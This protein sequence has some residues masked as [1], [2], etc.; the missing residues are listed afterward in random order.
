MRIAR[1][2]VILGLFLTAIGRTTL[3][4]SGDEPKPSPPVVV[5]VDPVYLFLN[6]PNDLDS[7]W[8]LIGRPDRV[9]LDGNQYRKLLDS[10][11]RPKPLE[12]RSPAVIES[13]LVAGQVIGDWAHLKL[14]LRVT[15]DHDEPEWIG[16]R[17]DGQTL[18]EAREGTIDLPT[19]MVGDRAW[20]VELSKKGNHLVQVG[21]IAPVKS[22]V[23]GK[24]IELMIPAAASTAIDLKLPVI[25]LDGSTGLNEKLAIASTDGDPAG[26]RL[27]ARL[28]PRSRLELNWRERADP[29]VKLPPLLEARGDVA[30]DVEREAILTRSTWGINSIRGTSGQLLLRL[31]GDEEILDILV[32]SR[33]VPWETRRE[34]G[35]S[36]VVIPL[37]EP[38]R[39]GTSRSLVLTTRRPI[40]S[41]GTV[42]AVLEGYS[43]DQA[44]VETGM[45]AVSRSGPLF[46]NPMSSRG[47]RRIDPRTELSESLRRRADTVLG[48][49][50]N[51]PP[52][53]L[54]LR[55][56]PA[57]PRL[58]VEEWTTIQIDPTTAR[59]QTRLDCRTSQGRVFE[60]QVLLPAGLDL[61]S[62]EP[63]D[64]VAS[65]HV[66][67]LNQPGTLGVGVDVPRILS[68]TL[69]PKAREDDSFAIYL[70]GWAAIDPSKSVAVPLFRPVADLSHGGRFAVVTDRNVAVELRPT[71]DAPANFRSDWAQPPTDWV[72]PGRKPGPEQN[73]LWLRTDAS[74]ETIPFQVT[75]RPRT[76]RHETTLTATIDRRGAEIV[77]EI[78]GEV[79]F[80]TLGKLDLSIPREVNDR[81]EVEGGDRT[82]REPLVETE[83]DGSRRYRLRFPRD[84]TDTFRLRIRY[85]LP[86]VKTDP[87]EAGG[88][89][90]L[91]PIR[92]LEGTSTGRKIQIAIEP[93]FEVQPEATG[94]STETGSEL[95]V[96]SENGLPI[97][98]R[99]TLNSEKAGPVALIVRP[100]SRLPL[101]GVM[102][103]RLW[104][105]TSQRPDNELAT[106]AFFWVES[107]ET[108]MVIGLDPGTR[109]VRT[110]VGTSELGAGAVEQVRPDEYRLRFPANTPTGPI[111]VAIDT[112]V[113]ASATRESWPAPRLLGG[114][115]VQQT[116]WEALLIGNRAGVGTPAGWLD[117]NEWFWDGLIWQRRPWKSPL[118]LTNW[119]TAGNSR[120]RPVDSFDPDDRGNRHSYLFS[121][122]G[123]PTS[124]RFVIFSRFTLLLL[125]SGPVLMAGLLVLAFRPPPRLTTAALLILVFALGSVVDLSVVFLVLQSSVL[126]LALFLTAVVI[127]WIIER[128][129]PSRT[130]GDLG[131]IVPITPGSTFD[132]SPAVGSEDSTAI[133]V[134]PMPPS[135]VST[136]DHIVLTRNFG[137]LS[138]VERTPPESDLP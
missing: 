103:S 75:V 80:G 76:I 16:L 40:A 4:Q 22:T 49:E 54:I 119:L 18:G 23:E 90:N 9:I 122:V 74:P 77:E 137:R 138:S 87:T 6:S 5:P 14:E 53:E 135:A 50:F 118:E 102:V 121:R 34:A 84:Y 98:I 108:P 45:I 128:R 41:E 93:G 101:P 88:R 10:A 100:A 15:L 7:F 133:R 36:V 112:I 58:R 35:Q 134:R 33:S 95:N 89:L 28:S 24:R 60:V 12:L 79:A 2:L 39:P 70:K 30:I 20:Q 106:S 132:R 56:E 73:V 96:V 61:E 131:T 32:D 59:I 124:L 113:P 86:F 85:R 136:A 25:V 13:V 114:G 99:L 120:Y 78:A 47:L 19:R 48:Y 125:C 52:Y 107:H 105:R 27:Q 3:A 17:L 29:A 72:W 111:L 71:S 67:P 37:A 91:V 11:E 117:E 64:A 68:I 21:L 63:A 109:L 42:R 31:S 51:G 129:N 8:K 66:V 57:P 83:A 38:I 82:I 97:Q 126:G 110:R 62:T 127:H 115:V 94:W 55:I 104:I 1:S 116:I 43:F 123:S 26:T 69:T 92:M 46:L 44:K 81:W 130:P 65:I